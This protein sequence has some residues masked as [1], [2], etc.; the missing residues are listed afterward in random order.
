MDTNAIIKNVSNLLKTDQKDIENYL[1]KFS[2]KIV[3]S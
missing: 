2:K 1:K 3:F